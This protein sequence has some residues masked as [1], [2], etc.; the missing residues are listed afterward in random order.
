MCYLSSHMCTSH[1]YWQMILILLSLCYMHTAARARPT[2]HTSHKQDYPADSWYVGLV[3]DHRAWHQWLQSIRIHLHINEKSVDTHCK[4]L[5]LII[6]EHLKIVTHLYYF[7]KL[8]AVCQSVKQVL[9]LTSACSSRSLAAAETNRAVTSLL[10]WD[11]R[12][13]CT[14]AVLAR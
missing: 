9:T 10:V 6:K 4:R 2:Y 13:T 3:W 14:T 1:I 7:I 8:T 11:N 12:I 5:T